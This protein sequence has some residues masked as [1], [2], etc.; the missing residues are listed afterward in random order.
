MVQG[1]L[2]GRIRRPGSVR[3]RHL[4]EAGRRLY[5]PVRLLEPGGSEPIHQ[6]VRIPISS[7]N[8]M[9]IVFRFSQRLCF[10]LYMLLR[11]NFLCLEELI[12]QSPIIDHC[13]P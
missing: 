13:L 2:P 6:A 3:A 4:G 5:K 8:D 9:L 11:G 10:H 12:E 1:T 7:L